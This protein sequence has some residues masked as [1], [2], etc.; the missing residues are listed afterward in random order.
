MGDVCCIIGHTQV[1]PEHSATLHAVLRQELA[2]LIE[3]GVT[4]FRA[5]GTAGFSLLAANIVVEYK[6]QN[7]ALRLE[8]FLPHSGYFA[9][10]N[11][12]ELSVFRNLLSQVDD[13]RYIS[14]Q[15]DGGDGT[16][17]VKHLVDGSQYCIAYL[18]RDRGDTAV[19][20]MYA[21][22]NSIDVLNI[23]PLL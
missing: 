3:A 11:Y 9:G 20:V 22:Q 1:L 8:L 5:S 23:A 2:S 13:T 6:K 19:A 12:D 4:T 14:W 10:W 16:P 17:W 21:K 7:P 18:V 15:K